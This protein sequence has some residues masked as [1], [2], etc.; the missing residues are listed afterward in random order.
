[1]SIYRY[2]LFVLVVLSAG[3][4]WAEEVQIRASWDPVTEDTRGNPLDPDDY[5]VYVCNEPILSRFADPFTERPIEELCEGKLKYVA[6]KDTQADVAYEL[7]S[8]SSLLYVRVSARVYVEDQGGLNTLES[9]LSE[10]VKVL[11]RARPKA[12]KDV[13][14]VLP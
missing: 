1:M 14:V 4:V 12:P 3:L 11:L 5:V 6:V 10:Q 13:N 9:D 2:V 8:L 7:E